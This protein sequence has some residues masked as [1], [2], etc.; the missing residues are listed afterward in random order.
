MKVCCSQR[1]K[2]ACLG[3]CMLALSCCCDCTSLDHRQTDQTWIHQ[4]RIVDDLWHL[5]RE[6]A[7]LMQAA[8]STCPVLPEDRPAIPAFLG[9]CTHASPET[10]ACALPFM[11]LLQPCNG[12]QADL[13][14][15]LFSVFTTSTG[16]LHFL[17]H[18]C[19]VIQ[20]I[21]HHC[22]L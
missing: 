10:P 9:V 16:M 20:P 15:D 6:H 1:Q 3:L 7:K 19:S 13:C 2:W 4:P 5:R 11:S 22:I 18:L 21:I 14:L 8:R 17:P 12:V